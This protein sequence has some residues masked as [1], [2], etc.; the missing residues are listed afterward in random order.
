M[1]LLALHLCASA[2]LRLVARHSHAPSGF[3]GAKP[4]PHAVLRCCVKLP[5]MLH[6]AC[7]IPI[8]ACARHAVQYERVMTRRCSQ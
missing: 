5:G 2:P 3:G 6:V 1:V 7:S 8:V 4:I